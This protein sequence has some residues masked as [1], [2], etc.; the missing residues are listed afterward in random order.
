M[1]EAPRGSLLGDLRRSRKLRVA[2]EEQR[3]S[4]ASALLRGGGRAALH[5]A[6]A[7]IETIAKPLRPDR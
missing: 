2:V 3:R 7:G 1:L 6:I 5:F 4:L